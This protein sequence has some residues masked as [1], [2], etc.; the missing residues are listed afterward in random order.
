MRQVIAVSVV[1]LA[2]AGATS[3]LAQADRY[4]GVGTYRAPAPP[5]A[6][7]QAQAA[8]GR[9]LTWPGKSTPAAPPQPYPAAYPQAYPA[10]PYA[11]PAYSPPRPA[12]PQM[13]PQAAY[14]SPYQPQPYYAPAPGGPAAPPGSSATAPTGVYPA[15][16]VPPNLA[17]PMAVPPQQAQPLVSNPQLP[18]S[19]YAPPAPPPPAGVL[20][21]AQPRRDLA[22][23]AAPQAAR[24][25]SLH[26]QFGLQPDR[27]PAPPAEGQPVELVS[28]IDSGVGDEPLSESRTRVVPASKAKGAQ[29]AALRERRGDDAA[30]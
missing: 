17:S 21:A 13:A 7:L 25:Y 28:S 15:N 29:T 10:Q 8:P 24:Y 30:N 12:P 9:V 5:R 18:N 6:Q 16:T 20:G 19:I 27:P 11:P 3:A 14:P 23:A 22:V 1:A 26:R 2:A 4:G